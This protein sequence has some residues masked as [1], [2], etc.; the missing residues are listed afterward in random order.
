MYVGPV[1]AIEEVEELCPWC[2][3]D[4]SAA[5]TYD[6]EFTDVEVGVPSELSASVLDEIS[7]R[8]P[9]FA[10]WQSERWMYHCGDACAFLGPVG[11]AELLSMPEDANVA[12][13]AESEDLDG[14]SADQVQTM[15]TDLSREGSPRGYLFQCL[16]CQAFKGYI[17]FD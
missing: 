6:A 7:R 14:W 13:A 10:G 4:G 8:T 17:D 5:E 1:Y 15:L 16:H 11:A 12:I 2:I 9:G 3:A